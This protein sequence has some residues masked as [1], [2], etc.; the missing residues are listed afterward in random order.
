MPVGSPG[1]EASEGYCTKVGSINP[2]GRVVP[3]ICR[4]S[5]LNSVITFTAP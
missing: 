2:P 3:R 5:G 4:T 1:E